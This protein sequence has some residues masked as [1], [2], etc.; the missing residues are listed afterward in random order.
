MRN[1]QLI[2]AAVLAAGCV[3]ANAAGASCDSLAS[4]SLP[5]TTITLARQVVAGPFTA[6]GGNE[7]LEKLPAFCRVA[8][9]LKPSIDSDI[10]VEVWMP[11]SG[12]NGKFQAVGNCG[13]AGTISYAA[14]ATA[15]ESGYTAAS[16]DT[17][18][19]AGA[20]SFALG[21]RK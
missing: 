13:W 17:G 18:H 14:M 10:K 5:D 19:T 20:A 6:P 21:R 7:S 2:L 8:A 9:T 12:W 15:V 3:A 1:Q 11:V 4:L 16:T